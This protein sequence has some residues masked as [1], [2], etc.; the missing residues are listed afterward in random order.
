MCD[1]GNE[2]VWKWYM[3]HHVRTIE[4]CRQ[5]GHFI[6]KKKKLKMNLLVRTPKAKIVLLHHH[7]LL[8]LLFMVFSFKRCDLCIKTHAARFIATT[9]EIRIDQ[10][11]VYGLFVYFRVQMHCLPGRV[12]KRSDV[13][14]YIFFLRIWLLFGYCW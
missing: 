10:K 11:F 1:T 5:F 8:L 6:E 12:W 4:Y 3:K 14:T 2:D 9:A 13:Y 7:H